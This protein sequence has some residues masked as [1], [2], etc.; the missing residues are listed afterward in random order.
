M[1]RAITER[2]DD[3]LTARGAHLFIEDVD[4]MDLIERFG[5]PLFV[6]SEDQLRRNVRS[7]KDSFGAGWSCGPSMILPAVKT[8]WTLAVQRILAS[9][10]CGADTYSPGELEIA[11]RA[12]MPVRYI[13]VNGVPKDEDHIARTLKLGARL[14]IDSLAD[15]VSLEKLAPS[16]DNVAPVAIRLRPMLGQYHRRSDFAPDGP[17]PTDLVAAAYKGGLSLSE[18]IEAAR[19]VRRLDNVELVGF[20]QHHGRH[21]PETEYWAAQMTAYAEDIAA[22]CDALGGYRPQEVDIGGGFAIP[23]DPHNAAT[24]Y[25]APYQMAALY[26]LSWALHKLGSRLR[27]KV[28]EPLLG[29]ASDSPN[30]A[31]A[32]SIADYARVVTR[33][34]ME[35]LH[36][37]GVD[38]EGVMLQVEPGRSVHGNAGVHLATVR[39]TKRR[40]APLPWTH[41]TV[42]TTEF[43]LTGGRYERHLHDYRVANK[44]GAPNSIQADVCGRSCYGDR[45]M[46]GVPLPE[47]STGDVI[48]FLDTGAYQEVSC[49]NFNAMP[50]PAAVLVQGDD[51]WVIRERESIED[52]LRRD[53]VPEH[54][55]GDAAEPARKRSL[56]RV[57]L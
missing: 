28:L 21:R 37:R 10:G 32:P 13:S 8:N 24:D 25:G 33:T 27:Y 54:L 2:L 9:E 14:T 15:V 51:A 49:S 16:L 6:F 48:A 53:R 38:P 20:H 57:A 44:I 22:V 46:G 35:Q 39:A 1:N 17:L 43:W 31:P 19:R 41:V 40:D 4:A 12:G 47:I 18:A 36:R 42:D 55:A 34:L 11:L 29:L 50:R 7:Y 23:R 45:L 52:V 3:C 56:E 5:S 30:A 26:G